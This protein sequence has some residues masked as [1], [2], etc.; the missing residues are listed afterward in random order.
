MGNYIKKKKKQI[1]GDRTVRGVVDE[2]RCF[3]SSD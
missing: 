3:D 1:S 2:P